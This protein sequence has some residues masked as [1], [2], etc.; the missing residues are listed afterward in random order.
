MFSKTDY[1]VVTEKALRNRRIR[2]AYRDRT[3]EPKDSGWRMMYD[4]NED[5]LELVNP[6]K[7]YACDIKRLTRYF[8]EIETFIKEK[9]YTVAE[10]HVD[11]FEL[12][13]DK[14]LTAVPNRMAGK[15]KYGVLMGGAHSHGG[16][17]IFTADPA[18][19]KSFGK[20]AWEELIPEKSE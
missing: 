12:T 13:R 2:F 1:A 10:Y 3:N 15:N 8:P 17:A 5:R 9:V 11:K 20:Q 16:G 19:E 4:K 6:D 14:E 18:D 7:L